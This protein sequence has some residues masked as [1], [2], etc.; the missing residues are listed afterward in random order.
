LKG[1]KEREGNRV[2][3]RERGGWMDE[4]WRERD[5]VEGFNGEHEWL[6]NQG[7]SWESL[8]WPFLMR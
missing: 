2:L 6:E 7:S 3:G 4:L 1:F 5:R 8:F